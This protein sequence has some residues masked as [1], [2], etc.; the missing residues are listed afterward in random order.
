M[1]IL[2]L[3][4]LVLN[5]VED[6]PVLLFQ[7]L[8]LAFKFNDQLVFL[9]QL[10]LL[11]ATFLIALVSFLLF[12]RSLFL[13]YLPQVSFPLLQGLLELSDFGLGI[14]DF[15]EDG[16]IVVASILL[17][18]LELSFL[19]RPFT[20]RFPL[21]LLFLLEE[22]ILLVNLVVLYRQ[23]GRLFGFLYLLVQPLQLGISGALALCMQLLLLVV[24]KAVH[25]V[26]HLLAAL[27]VVALK[28]SS[29][30]A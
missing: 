21:Q 29:G 22:H 15:F 18:L 17:G 7:F 26:G 1:L 2:E 24:D 13:L 10:S 14:L 4:L 3:P 28:L 8:Q 5:E 27:I 11:L 16:L 23:F 25:L 19:D 20:L 6:A 30:I 12:Q 9:A